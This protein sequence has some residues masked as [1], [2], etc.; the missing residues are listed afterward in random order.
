MR[1]GQARQLAA[2]LAG[3]G[4][5]LLVSGCSPAGAF[6]P[7]A[8]IDLPLDGSAI[9]A[10]V[11]V[12]VRSHA[13]APEGVAEIL[14]AVNGEAYRRDPPD[15]PGEA[16]TQVSQAWL[17]AE[18]GDYALEVVAYSTSGEAS[19]P[20]AA[21]VHVL[22]AATYT[23][24][25]T[26][27][28]APT[29]TSTI[30][31]TPYVT[32]SVDRPS[33]VQGE[34]TTLRWRTGNAVSA[35]LDGVSVPLEGTQSV[36]PSASTTYH[37]HVIALAGPVDQ[38]VTVSVSA[39]AD[40]TPPTIGAVSASTTMI[41]MPNCTPNTATITAQVSDAGGVAQVELVYRVTGG[42]WQSR[43]MSGSGGSYQV[44]LDWLALQASR[45][46]VPTTAGSILEYYVRARDAAGNQT[47]TGTGSITLS[48]CLI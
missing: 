36:C 6:G 26:L 33:L 34:C 18:P 9:V 39:P 1:K 7:Q 17:P 37:L 41:R 45:D 25:V 11:E 3:T 43:S 32:F 24:I 27:T 23:P 10:G 48:G 22:P 4:P 29:V 35:S 46:P 31:P 30:P 13:F 8:W 20:A 16:F 38:A 2:A 44:T 14:L 40:T 15:Q 5:V 12:Q 47:Q 28:P 42:A 21:W 19:A